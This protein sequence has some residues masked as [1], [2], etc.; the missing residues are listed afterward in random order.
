MIKRNLHVVIDGDFL[1][2]NGLPSSN[3]SHYGAFVSRYVPYFNHV[4]LYCRVHKT[5]DPNGLPVGGE[6][7]TVVPLPEVHGPIGLLKNLIFLLKIFLKICANK[8]DRALIRIPGIFPTVAWF[9]FLI[10]GFPYAVE[11]MADAEAQFSKEAFQRPGRL[12]YKIIWTS[13]MK[14][15]CRLASS[16]AYVTKRAL[17]NQYP[18]GKNCP[19]FSFTTL[20]LP[21][22]MIVDSPKTEDFFKQRPFKFVNVAMMQ[23]HLKGQDIIL[24]A[25]AIFSENKDVE[26]LLVGDG[27]TR[28]D[29]E[30]LAND[31]SVAGKV[32]F[33]GRKSAGQEI[34]DILDVSHVF[35]LPSRQEGLPRVV[36]EAMARGLPCVASDLPGNYELL[37]DDFIVKNNAVDGWVK[38]FER[39]WNN[40]ELLARVSK[41]NT[42]KSRY[43]SL[44]NVASVRKLF[45]ASI[46]DIEK[47]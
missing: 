12:I 27:D 21:D 22:S 37:E 29:F 3:R 4:F 19:S 24:K 18:A 7:V 45:Y 23:K 34:F 25:F 26:L 17:Q 16:A 38:V 10:K 20:D 14:W 9:V 15:Q 6:G 42:E 30:K 40:S 36:I 33:L 1:L 2:T 41:I 46:N 43:Y 13:A 5:E 28:P 31:L 32:K 47:I 8:N 39:I 11:A 44:S 35:V